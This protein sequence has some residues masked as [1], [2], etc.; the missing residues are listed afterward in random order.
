MIAI[1]DILKEINLLEPIPR[2]A[3]KLAALVADANSTI[4]QV[5]EV[6]RYD[7]AFTADIL[8]LAN[9]AFSGAQRRIVDLKDA[10]VRLGGARILEQLLGK[11]VRASMQIPI[12]G[13]GYGEDELWRHSVAAATAA[14]NIN[15]LLPKP[16]GGICFTAAL[17]HDIGKL[18]ICRIVSPAIMEEV[19]SLVSRQSM[20]L[21]GEMAEKQVLGFSHADIGAR[22]ASAWQLPD[23]IV[24]AIGGHHNPNAVDEPVTDVV[25]IANL[26]ARSI[27]EGLGREGMSLA[28]DNEVAMR[29]GLTREA[30]ERL[31]VKTADKF[32][33]IMNM[34]DS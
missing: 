5:T 32:E 24:S 23:L 12:T 9:S 30:F 29:L 28:V 10:V 20:P 34:F 18:I 22:I 6:I 4:E 14:E 13:Y 19:W 2:T 1:D 27:G 21:T 33:T 26:T 15:A 16:I 31:C 3:V 25:K 7:P 17:L 11:K 8:K